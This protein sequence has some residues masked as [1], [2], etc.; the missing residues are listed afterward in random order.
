MNC[1]WKFISRSLEDS[2]HFSQGTFVIFLK[3][4]R[5]LHNNTNKVTIRH[6]T[7]WG[8]LYTE[9]LCEETKQQYQSKSQINVTAWGIATSLTTTTRRLSVPPLLPP[10][11]CLD[12]CSDHP[13]YCL[14]DPHLPDGPV[15]LSCL[16]CLFWVIQLQLFG[17]LEGSILLVQAKKNETLRKDVFIMFI[18]CDI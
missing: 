10:A 14:F 7:L 6:T 9:G 16:R 18:Y 12:L 13:N 17:P 1:R 2:C 5:M 3:L 4:M 11:A 15:S 8:G